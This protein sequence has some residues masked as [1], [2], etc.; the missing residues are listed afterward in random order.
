MNRDTFLQRRSNARSKEAV[1]P[2]TPAVREVRHQS[3]C[4]FAASF[5]RAFE[6]SNEAARR[7]TNCGHGVGYEQ[8][9]DHDQDDHG[10]DAHSYESWSTCATVR[11]LSARSVF[12]QMFEHSFEHDAERRPVSLGGSR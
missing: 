9:C 3:R 7:T 4:L 6:R 8:V 10:Q 11:P 5:E 1:T 2:T 12:E